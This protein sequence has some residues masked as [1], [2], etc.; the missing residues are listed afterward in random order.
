MAGSINET[1]FKDFEKLLEPPRMVS[2]ARKYGPLVFPNPEKQVREIFEHYINNEMSQA[3]LSLSSTFSQTPEGT[4]PLSDKKIANAMGLYNNNA[5]IQQFVLFSF[6][7]LRLKALSVRYDKIPLEILPLQKLGLFANMTWLDQ[8]PILDDTSSFAKLYPKAFYRLNN[9][10]GQYPFFVKKFTNVME[11]QCYCYDELEVKTNISKAD[12]GTEDGYKDHTW[13][14]FEVGKFGKNTYLEEMLIGEM[15][16]AGGDKV[17][18]AETWNENMRVPIYNDNEGKTINDIGD[19]RL[20]SVALPWSMVY[21]SEP[22]VNGVFQN[23]SE[24]TTAKKDT[25]ISNQLIGEGYYITNFTFEHYKTRW[26]D[27]NWPDSFFMTPK[28]FLIESGYCYDEYVWF[29]QFMHKTYSIATLS[30]YLQG[31][32]HTLWEQDTDLNTLF[33]KQTLN[34]GLKGD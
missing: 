25:D 27:E 7:F 8:E 4:P 23:P 26:N 16:R 24:K 18:Y 33:S 2:N 11:E 21:R 6:Y 5:K 19:T 28:Q 15:E 30:T 29:K 14:C 31:C 13:Q 17:F 3:E 12:C 9:S 32:I 34:F 22:K 1:A 20:R 10:L